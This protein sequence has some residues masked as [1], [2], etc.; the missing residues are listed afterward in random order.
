MSEVGRTLWV[1]RSESIDRQVIAGEVLLLPPDWCSGTQ[2]YFIFPKDTLAPPE[3]A[4]SFQKILHSRE[5][6][7]SWSKDTSCGPKDTLSWPK[8]SYPPRKYL[9]C[10]QRYFISG[11]N[12][13]STRRD[14]GS[15]A[16][17]GE[18]RDLIPA[19]SDVTAKWRART[20]R[21]QSILA[22]LAWR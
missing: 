14:K 7:L 8:I 22:R 15:G 11:E 17:P 9:M 2:R 18:F 10:R 12:T 19:R 5:R 16:P 1:S 3:D 4:L 6:Y 13:L 21:A 20:R